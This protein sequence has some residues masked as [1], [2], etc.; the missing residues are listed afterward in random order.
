MQGISLDM[1]LSVNNFGSVTADSLKLEFSDN[2]TDTVFYTTYINVPKDTFST[3]VK[4]ILTD[5]LLYTAPVSQIDV[6]VVGTLPDEEYY[7]F[8]NLTKGS[9]YVIRDSLN[10]VFNITFDGRN[11]DWRSYLI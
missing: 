6:K 4:T 10:P 5:N 9:F 11:S 7:T 8:N 3:T 1:N 2:I